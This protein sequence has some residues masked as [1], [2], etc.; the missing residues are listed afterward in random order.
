MITC[1]LFTLP[2]IFKTNICCTFTKNI[3]TFST[4]KCLN[5]CFTASEENNRTLILY[6]ITKE[7]IVH[8]I[9]H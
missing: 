6:R 9:M 2:S 7:K 8:K 1:D 3:I 4:G 5:R